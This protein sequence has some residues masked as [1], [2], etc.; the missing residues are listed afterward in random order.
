[1]FLCCE[2]S[3]IFSIFCRPPIYVKAIAT[4][5]VLLTPVS[6]LASSRFTP[7]H[8]VRFAKNS[9]FQDASWVPAASLW[10][11]RLGVYLDSRKSSG[12]KWLKVERDD[13][14]RN[15]WQTPRPCREELRST[16]VCQCL[17]PVEGAARTAEDLS[18][19]TSTW[20]PRVCCC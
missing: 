1:V 4:G 14:L 18:Q 20:T 17:L 13:G 3:D 19:L 8:G 10:L 15:E 16:V 9:Q 2:I 6:D 5:V 12:L 11:L 7:R